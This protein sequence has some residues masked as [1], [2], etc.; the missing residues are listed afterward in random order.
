VYHLSVVVSRSCAIQLR[1]FEEFS[2]QGCSASQLDEWTNFQNVNALKVITEDKL[3][4]EDIILV[5]G[6]DISFDKNDETRACAFVTI[7][8]MVTQ[9]VVHEEFEVCNLSVPY[10]SGYLGFR[11]IELYLPLLKRLKG[12][13][14]YPQ[15]LM[16]DGFGILHHRGFG[17]ASHIGVALNI[18]TIGI[19]KTLLCM[20]GLDEQM[21][22]EQFRDQCKSAGD[23][24]HLTGAEPAAKVYGAALKSCQGSINPIFVTIGHMISLDTAIRLTMKASKYRIPEP[25]RNSDIK[26]KPPLLSVQP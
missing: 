4:I 14:F 8:N 21:V 24:I 11:E 20:D 19:G 25:I 3:L 26:S 17:S 23:Y 16:V 13:E 22:K 5:G 2:M 15:L 7:Y 10:I 12:T 6:L 18:P 9:S 1:Q